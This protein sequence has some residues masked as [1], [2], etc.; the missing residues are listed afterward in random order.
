MIVSVKRLARSAVIGLMVLGLGVAKPFAADHPDVVV[1][2]G[3][4]EG[5]FLAG[6]LFHIGE[7][8]MRVSVDT[9]FNRW[10]SGGLSHHAVVKLTTHPERIGDE[11]NLRILT[12]TLK[13][14]TAP[15]PTPTTTN[16]VGRLPQGDSGLVHVLFLQDD[17]TGSLGAVTFETADLV[18]VA[19]FD[20][21]D[22][23]HVSIVIAIDGQNTR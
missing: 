9:E 11:R 13:H 2:S 4:L 14:E 7:F 12:G 10:L 21:Y 15:K 23:A 20:A 22:G 18:T 19:A 6:S 8:W 17:L 3:T 1:A 16:V 5:W